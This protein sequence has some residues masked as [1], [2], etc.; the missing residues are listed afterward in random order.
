VKGGD[1]NGG[2][3]TLYADDRYIISWELPNN[4]AW[5]DVAFSEY[6]LDEGHYHRMIRRD[7]WKLNYYHGQE[8]QLFNLHQDPDE[9]VDRAQDPS[10]REVREELENEV[11]RDWDPDRIARRMQARRA[12]LSLIMDW[13]KHTKP[14]NHC[15]WDRRPEMDYR[16]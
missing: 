16:D 5:E 3:I 12:D 2:K 7:E 6:C 10:C 13:V 1:A 4:V 11:L 15:I 14:E 9:L 8:P